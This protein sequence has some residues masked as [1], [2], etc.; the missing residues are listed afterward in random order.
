VG[1]GRESKVEREEAGL[2]WR[3]AVDHGRRE[4]GGK[5]RERQRVRRRGGGRRGTEA[6]RGEEGTEERTKE[7]GWRG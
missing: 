6:E 2:A 4:E 5:Q 3:L 7:E 1:R